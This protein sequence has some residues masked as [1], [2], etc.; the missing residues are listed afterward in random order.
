M[1]RSV[2]QNVG[3]LAWSDPELDTATKDQLD[4]AII[5]C[6][7]PPLRH[8]EIGRRASF[9]KSELQ[10]VVTVL[11]G[12]TLLGLVASPAFPAGNPERDA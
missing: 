9:M 6:I 4:A 7:V 11:C 5:S 1:R 2:A 10:W 8:N 3:Q 12:S